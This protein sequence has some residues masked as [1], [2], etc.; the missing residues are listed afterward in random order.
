MV[1]VELRFDRWGIPEVFAPDPEGL[2]FGL[3][4]AHASDRLFQLEFHR[5]A[6]AGRLS[7]L[8]GPPAL[9]ADRFLRRL[10]LVPRARRDWE[11]QPPDAARLLRAYAA[12]VNARLAEGGAA[13][14]PEFRLLNYEPA[15]WHPVDSLAI[16]RL[17]GWL[18]STNWETELVRLELVRRLGPDRAARL[19]PLTPPEAYA[20]A[21]GPAPDPM[22]IRQRLLSAAAGLAAIL[23]VGAASNAW[24]VA[25]TRSATA[26]PLLAADPHLRPQLPALWYLVRLRTPEL[27]A[28]GASIPGLFGLSLGRSRDCAWGVTVAFADTQDLFI[29]EVRPGPGGDLLARTADGWQPVRS[30]VETFRAGGT[31]QR[32]VCRETDH[33]PLILEAEGPYWVSLAASALR[34]PVDGS[35]LYRLLT[36]RSCADLEA[37]VR[38]WTMPTLNFIAAD[39]AGNIVYRMA[40]R[41]P[42]RKRA[43]GLVPAPAW[44]PEAAWDGWLDPDRLPRLANPPAGFVFSANEFPALAGAGEYLG[45]DWPDPYRAARIHALLA[46]RPRHTVRDFLAYQQDLVSVPLQ[47]LRDYVLRAAPTLPPS[48]RTLL[49]E[50]DG[51]VRADSAAAGFLEVLRVEL[52]RAWFEAA[53]LDSATVALLTGQGLHPFAPINGFAGR[54]SGFLL[55]GLDRGL[56][57][58]VLPEAVG[59]TLAF[60]IR[61]AGRNPARWR[62]GR[63]HRL[64]FTRPLGTVPG[65]GRLWRG[66]DLPLGGDF[67][68]VAQAS[69]MPPAAFESAGWVPSYRQVVDLADPEGGYWVIN[70]GQSGNPLSR[71]YFDQLWVWYRGGYLRMGSD[72]AVRRVRLSFRP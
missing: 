34:A 68:T 35:V 19:E 26:R 5:L 37:V 63:V 58:G 64:R 11:A 56:F 9:D 38:D 7:E 10:G 57:D 47:R 3:G 45:A 28:V 43:G 49:A 21:P 12:G 44:D 71:H 55:A 48:V 52:V 2:A 24:A 69:F 72:R 50:W 15:P 62:W 17:I 54:L 67:D 61:R 25:S 41:I 60:W 20:Y 14:A 33:G 29:E 42:A 30:R 51:A 8:L 27:W 53:G 39:T 65:I 70:T 4:Y 59:R 23:P 6:A 18:L 1:G 16:G 46:G 66:P 40:G 36:A 13:T 31:V 22:E 32:E